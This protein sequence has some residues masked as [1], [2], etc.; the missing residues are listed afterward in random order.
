MIEAS[1]RNLYKI[2]IPGKFR[3]THM[4]TPVP[5]SLFNNVVGLQSVTFLKRNLEKIF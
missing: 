3:K 2:D 1:D 4:K 5:E